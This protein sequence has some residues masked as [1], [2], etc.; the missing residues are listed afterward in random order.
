MAARAIWKGAI[1]FGPVT[2]PVRLYSAV[3]DQDIHFHLLHDQDNVRLKQRMATAS[4]ETV[5]PAET[6]RGVEVEPGTFALINAEELASLEPQE[7]RRINIEKFVESE[8]I[9]HQWYER[10][11]YLGPDEGAETAYWAL[12]DTLSK[13][14]LEGVAHWVMRKRE[15]VGTLRVHKGYL[16]LVTTRRMDEV[17]PASEIAAPTGRKLD[18]R[19]M[20]MAGQLVSALEGDFQP[21]EFRDEYRSRVMELI[22]SKARGE[23]IEITKPAEKAAI[24]SLTDALKASIAAA[25][26][27]KAHA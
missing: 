9:S 16:M 27:E 1:S 12:V 8:Q 2:I 24:R 3:Q 25:K 6:K 22:E 4:S 15:Y 7:S 10:P 23:K 18:E 17:V 13:H 19:E 11:Y 14:K 20:H 5:E 21:A 26:K